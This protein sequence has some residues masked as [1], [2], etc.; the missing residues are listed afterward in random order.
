MSNPAEP[1]PG[2]IRIRLRFS[3]LGKVRFTSHRDTARIWERALRRVDA[4]VAYSEGFSPRPRLSFG[5]ALSTGHESLGEYLDV[6]LDLPEDQL[7][8]DQLITRLDPALPVGFTVQGAS[9]V[10]P[11]TPSVSVAVEQL[12]HRDQLVVTRERK[13]RDVTEDLRPALLELA[14]QG[15]TPSGTELVAELATQPRALRPGDLLGVLAGL[16]P[17]AAPGDAA[18]ASTARV[19]R[20]H[21]WMVVGDER[22]EPLAAP[23][24][25]PVAPP[26]QE[27][28]AS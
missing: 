4:P 23:S 24:P 25:P 9:V 28:R 7:D 10:E 8:L 13:G 19:C 2:R 21:Q 5:L 26:L 17:G 11:G 15:P 3:K 12:L 14:P 1:H 6:D 27:L 18:L 20:T 22:R 16:V